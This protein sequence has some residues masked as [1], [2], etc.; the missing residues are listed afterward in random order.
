MD[1]IGKRLHWRVVVFWFPNCGTASYSVVPFWNVSAQ[2]PN[3]KCGPWQNWVIGQINQ[4]DPSIVV[5]TSSVHPA[6]A[7]PATSITPAQWQTGLQQTLSMISAPNVQKVVV[8]DMSY[9][10]KSAPDCLAANVDNVQACS[11]PEASAVLGK[12]DVAES[13]AAAAT[14]AHYINVIPW[15]CSS[16]CTPIVGNILVYSDYGH[17]SETFSAYL[18]GALAS[19]LAPELGSR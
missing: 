19:A 16:T 2:R 5:L 3:D 10:A 9:L 11:T 18:S 13:Q 7:G 15:F 8:G 17:I 14:G 1:L 12:F 6:D 4:I